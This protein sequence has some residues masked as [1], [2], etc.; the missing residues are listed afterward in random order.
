MTQ[1]RV[2]EDEAL[3]E[4]PLELLLQRACRRLGRPESAG[5]PFA[6]ALRDQ[7]FDSAGSLREVTVY[8]TF[9]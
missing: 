9:S 4:E 6:R 5:A 3:D 8:L 2:P 7:W 1:P